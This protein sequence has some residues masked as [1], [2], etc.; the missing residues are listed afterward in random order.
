VKAATEALLNRCAHVRREDGSQEDL[1]PEL[2]TR[3]RNEA[4]ELALSGLR[5]LAVFE[6]SFPEGQELDPD[7]VSELTFVGLLA[8]RDPV[9]KTAKQALF[10]L[11]RAGLR[12]IMV[13]GDH[14]STAEA[15]AVELNLSPKP[16]I[17]TGAELAE[18]DDDELS[19]QVDRIDVFARVSPSQKVRIVRALSRAGR[20]VA[21]VG[22]GAND[23]PAIRLSNV[24]VAMGQHA[25]EAARNA[26]DIVLIDARVE[27][28][29]RA[30][31]EGRVLWDSVRDAVSILV[32]G[33]LGE[34][35]FT[36]FGGLISGRPPLSPRQ[37]LLVNLFTDVAPAT[38][39]ALRAPQ[40]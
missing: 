29:V 6:R 31:V 13:T 20:T 35:G 30:I 39:L 16:E 22:D 12:P 32:G 17:M 3:L 15:I 34:I 4:H 8:F 1:T 18:L 5:V 27:T 25:A 9:R 28:L 26:A 37:L 40:K 33:N 38:A 14:P 19:V 21:M 7:S 10:D 2:L 11:R 36:L 24:G 23:A